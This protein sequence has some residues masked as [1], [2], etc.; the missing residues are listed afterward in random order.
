MTEF[1]DVIEKRRLTS[2]AAPMQYEGQLRDGRRYYFRYRWGIAS[3]G[4]GASTVEAIADP[5]T[6][7]VKIGDELDGYLDADQFEEVAAHLLAHRTGHDPGASEPD[8]CTSQAGQSA[9]G[10]SAGAPIGEE[11]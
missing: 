5:D 10:E 8:G 11:A 6:V 4:I 3:L 2:I 9:G 1:P 7:S